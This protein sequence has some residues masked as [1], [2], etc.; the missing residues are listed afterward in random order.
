[1]IFDD[2][3]KKKHG[4]QPQ[5]PPEIDLD[6]MIKNFAAGIQKMLGGGIK[7]LLPKA[8]LL[9]VIIIL[10]WFATG[11]YVVQPGER[12]IIQRFGQAT[13]TSSPGPHW[14]LPYPIETVRKVSVE[15][16]RR[17]EIGF[18]TIRQVP[19]AQ[20]RKIPQEALMLTG[21]KNIVNI[22][23]IVQYK[24][25]DAINYL[26]NVKNPDDTVKDAA[27]A[28]M[29]EIVGRDH[30]DEVLTTGKFKIQQDAKA[31]L[32]KI[33]DKY[34]AGISIVAVQL[35]DV[36]PP[37]EVAHAFKDVQSAREDR[38][39]VINEAE[40]YRNDIIP[41]AKGEASNIINKAIAYKESKIKNAEGETSRYLQTLAEYSKA[42]NVT[43]KRLYIETMEEI[44]SKAEKIIIDKS[45]SNG[46]VPYLPLGNDGRKIK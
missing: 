43:R 7:K 32:Q 22:E 5:Q 25:R 3:D 8:G 6:E 26:F 11:L 21:D 41:K 1:M 30:I 27:E 9:V 31:L 33:I 38:E 13:Y 35:Q 46:I 4:Q 2:E 37:Q 24:V 16:V 15:H 17:V 29:R 40:G 36:T 45:A 18:K 14:H 20:Y 44:L 28:A 10:G 42:K 19:S 34:K 23:F 12:G 39:K